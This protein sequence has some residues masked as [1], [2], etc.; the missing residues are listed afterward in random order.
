MMSGDSSALQLTN[1][2]QY[3][4]CQPNT[5][6]QTTCKSPAKHFEDHS[7]RVILEQFES[8]LR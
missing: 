1:F 2:T 5:F 7:E 4:N 8:I 6:H 3:E